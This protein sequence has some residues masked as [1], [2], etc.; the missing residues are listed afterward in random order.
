MNKVNLWIYRILYLGMI[1]EWFIVR[2]TAMVQRPY[3]IL[4]SILIGL[5]AGV[6]LWTVFLLIGLAIL[7]R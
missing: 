4:K 3:W 1:Q 7:R 6:V 5:V 2:M